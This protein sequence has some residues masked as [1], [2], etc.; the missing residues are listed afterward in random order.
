M[1]A[2]VLTDDDPDDRGVPEHGG[3]DDDGEGGGPQLVHLT[4]PTRQQVGLIPPTIVVYHCLPSLLFIYF[5]TENNS[6]SWPLFFF[7]RP[8]CNKD[9]SCIVVV[10]NI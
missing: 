4:L 9:E 5:S 7:R 1:I 3:D 10:K 6:R 8:L 2:N